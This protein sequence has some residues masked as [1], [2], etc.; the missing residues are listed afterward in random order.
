MYE[1]VYDDKNNIE[2]QTEKRIADQHVYQT[3][4]FYYDTW[5]NPFLANLDD[6][7]KLFGCFN[8][9]TVGLFWNNASRPIFSS[10]NNVQSFKE[11]TST[12]EHHGLYE[13]QYRL[14]MPAAQF[15]TN[16]VVYYNYLITTE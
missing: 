13:Y 10:A 9:A 16:S 8:Y 1:L 4:Y 12:E 5:Q 15:G 7:E 14:G 6:G 3:F 11:V 2:T